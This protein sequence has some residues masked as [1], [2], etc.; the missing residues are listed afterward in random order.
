MS[1]FESGMVGKQKIS[2]DI[3]KKMYLSFK[4]ESVPDYMQLLK[5]Y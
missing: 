3:D 4:I 1:N 5:E 2:R